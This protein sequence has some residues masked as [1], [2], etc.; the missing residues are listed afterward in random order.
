MAVNAITTHEIIMSNDDAAIDASAVAAAAS[1]GAPPDNQA[2]DALLAKELNDLSL[3]NRTE[4]MEEMHC[5]KCPT[6]E[7]TPQLV[8][9]SINSLQKE[10]EE[11]PPNDREAYEDSLVM[12][13]QYFLQEDVQLKFLRAERFNAKRAAV[14]LAKNAKILL[15]HFGP[16]ALQ[17]ELRLSDLGKNEQEL[18]RLGHDQILPSRDR[19]VSS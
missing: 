4:I 7:E 18:L 12:D 11:L 10:I 8:Q 16:I 15:E 1:L 6:V 14:R 2:F 9:S 3:E 13:S 19:A 17:R 5:V